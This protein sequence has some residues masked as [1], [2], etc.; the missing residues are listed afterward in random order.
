MSD[1]WPR[2][3]AAAREN[4]WR[5]RFQLEHLPGL[6]MMLATLEVIVSPK[7]TE[8]TWRIVGRGKAPD[9]IREACA[10]QLVEA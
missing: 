10:R 2:L 1:C 9:D 5:V 4:G 7:Q 8:R 6:T 3:D